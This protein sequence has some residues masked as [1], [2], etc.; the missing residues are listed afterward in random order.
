MLNLE[1]A[2]LGAIKANLGIDL[3]SA[4]QVP[5]VVQEAVDQDRAQAEGLDTE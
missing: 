3:S 1:R 4:I 5:E 2:T